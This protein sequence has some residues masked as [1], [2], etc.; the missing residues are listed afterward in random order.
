MYDELYGAWRVEIENPELGR[1][2]PDFYA[3]AADYLRRI[4]EETQLNDKKAIRASLL[5]HELEN[6]QR[7]L[8]EVV[9]VRYRKLV[10]RMV[11]GQKVP[12]DLLAAEETKL[13]SGV[14]PSAEGYSKFAKSLLLGQAPRVEVEAAAP[15][16]VEHKRVTLRF[17][18]QVP[19]IIGS[20]MKT[21]GPFLVEDVAA[22]PS[23]NARILIK[24]HLAEAI[25]V[26]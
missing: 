4:K 19:S 21:Y 14:L 6:A 12:L 13:C 5:E 11:E 10:K 26:S 3:R 1:L 23:E 24:Q 17:L 9:W 25:E 15:M 7:M 20:D 16:Q 22:V 2:T 8:Y 18:K